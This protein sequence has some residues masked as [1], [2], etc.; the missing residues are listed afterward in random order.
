MGTS[1]FTEQ[2][3]GSY[4][5]AGYVPSDKETDAETER[6]IAEKYPYSEEQKMRREAMNALIVGETVPDD[7]TEYDNYINAC[8]A[9]GRAKKQANAD[10]MAALQKVVIP[11][12]EEAGTEEREIY[13]LPQPPQQPEQEA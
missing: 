13:V 9:D 7:Y 2:E 1:Y 10:R 11:G 5:L 4:L 12:D 8:V 6:L 3:D